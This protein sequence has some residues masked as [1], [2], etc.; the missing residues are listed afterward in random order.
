MSLDKLKILESLIKTVDGRTIMQNCD[1]CMWLDELASPFE[2]THKLE[3]MLHLEGLTTAPFQPNGM[4]IRYKQQTVHLHNI[5]ESI[6]LDQFLYF[7]N[8]LLHPAYEI[9][10]W[11]GSLG[12][13]T[14]AFI[15]LERELWDALEENMGICPV[16]GEFSR[17]NRGAHLF[18]LDELTSIQLLD[19]YT[20]FKGN[21]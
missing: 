4:L 2:I 18:Q 9:R 17:L 1:F 7:L 12:M 11:N 15:P 13:N 20:K 10:F 16:N 5:E 14:L 3:K 6:D 21:L 19:N 8:E